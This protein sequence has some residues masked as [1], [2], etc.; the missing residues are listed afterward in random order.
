MSLQLPAEALQLAAG[1]DGLAVFVAQV[2]FLL[3][4]LGLLLLQRP[5]LLLGVAVLFQL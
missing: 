4:E 5:H 2:V 1:Q 3:D